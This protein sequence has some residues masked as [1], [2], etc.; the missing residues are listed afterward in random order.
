[1]ALQDM[2]AFDEVMEALGNLLYLAIQIVG[3]LAAVA[4]ILFVLYIPIHFL[5]KYW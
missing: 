1:M 4:F 3:W 2:N 5:V